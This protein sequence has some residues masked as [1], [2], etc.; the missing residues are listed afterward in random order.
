[1]FIIQFRYL[2]VIGLAMRC[3]CANVR[4]VCL[5]FAYA[6]QIVTECANISKRK[7]SA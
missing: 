5:Q 7:E 6:S 2:Q 1:M 3:K 4:F